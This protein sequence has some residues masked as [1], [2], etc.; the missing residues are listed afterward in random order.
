MDIYGYHYGSFYLKN[1]TDIAN[2]D[3]IIVRGDYENFKSGFLV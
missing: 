2:L 3:I 1:F